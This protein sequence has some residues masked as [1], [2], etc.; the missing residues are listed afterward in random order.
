MFKLL[1]AVETYLKR[2][3]LALSNNLRSP[4][5]TTAIDFKYKRLEPEGGGHG[6]NVQVHQRGR[7]LPPL[8]EDD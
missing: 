3:D 2:L 4:F 8:E 6:G 5:V 7:T 1:P